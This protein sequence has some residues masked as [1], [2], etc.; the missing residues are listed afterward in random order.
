MTTTPVAT[1]PSVTPP[2]LFLLVAL[3]ACGPISTDLYLPSLPSLTQVFATDVSRVQLTLS[4]FIAGFALAQLVLGPLSDRYGRR[5]VL[6]GGFAVFLAA[7]VFCLLAP[8][9]EALILGRF[10]QALGGCAGPVIGRA[11]VRDAYPRDEAARVLSTMASTMALAPALAPFLGGALQAA[12]GWR[13]NFAVLV[14][15]ALLLLALAWRQLKETNRHPDPNAMSPAAMLETYAA[16]LTDRRFLVS[17]LTL[18][19]TFGGMFSFIS[20]S[21]FVII[22]VLGLAPQNFGFCF[23]VVVAGYMA[24]TFIAARL[25]KRIGLER[26]VGIGTLIG[27]AAGGLLLGLAFWRVQTVAAV[28]LPVALAFAAGGLIL[29]NGTAAALAPHPTIAGRA[30]ALMGC[31]QMAFGAGAGWLVGRLH[32]GTPLP[33]AA[34]IAAMLAGAAIC[35]KFNRPAS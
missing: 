1:P 35:W 7:S 21:S 5:P 17:T 29:P 14:V 4:V 34:V 19:F 2:P 26:M 10:L 32:D 20:G 30:S 16:L 22:D 33:M 9:I 27:L 15:F 12:F 28:I 11:I 8:S 3:V 6:L 25:T 13:A 31:I 24:G 23:I 18:S